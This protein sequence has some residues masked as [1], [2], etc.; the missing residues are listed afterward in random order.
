LIR[1]PDILISVKRKY[2]TRMLAGEKT[3]ELR[4]RLLRVNPG[5]RVWIYST[6]PDCLVEALATVSRIVGASPERLW[7][8]YRKKVGVSR[9]EFRTYFANRKVGY[10]VVLRD[11][12]ALPTAVGLADLRRGSG[13]FQP[14]QFFKRLQHDSP[15]LR[16]LI[17]S[18]EGP[19]ASTSSK[20]YRVPSAAGWA[21]RQNQ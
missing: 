16:M 19:G 10:A 20:V 13:P 1:T 4:R 15:T 6:A 17:W 21:T 11:I 14:P 5:T 18:V 3:I 12:R 9:A 8:K 2:V 7:Q